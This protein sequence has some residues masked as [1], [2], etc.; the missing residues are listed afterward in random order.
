MVAMLLRKWMKLLFIIVIVVGFALYTF[1][2]LTY[3]RYYPGVS[4]NNEIIVSIGSVKKAEDVVERILDKY[5]GKVDKLWIYKTNI[6]WSRK[7]IQI[8]Y[9]SYPLNY[10]YEF[11]VFILRKILGQIEARTELYFRAPHHPWDNV[12]WI[13][14]DRVH[15]RL[16][17][18][19]N[20]IF[21]GDEPSG[22]GN[23]NALFYLDKNRFV[24]INLV[25]AEYCI[26]NGTS[27]TTFK[28]NGTYIKLPSPCSPRD[29][30]HLRFWYIYFVPPYIHTFTEPY[31]EELA[32]VYIANIV[33][34]THNMTDKVFM[35]KNFR[36]YL[37][38]LRR[39]RDEWIKRFNDTGFTALRDEHG[40]VAELD[41]DSR[42]IP[43]T[44]ENTRFFKEFEENLTDILWHTLIKPILQYIHV[45]ANSL[46]DIMF[47]LLI[48]KHEAIY[49][50][51][52]T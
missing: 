4:G 46:W 27:L 32:P 20:G 43:Q 33:V 23:V 39:L 14:Y 17:I 52:L 1:F 26:P 8:E 44:L 30:E 3:Y 37:G 21:S 24:I 45:H 6:Y 47:A 29:R 48:N 35:D 38:E 12:T 16:L 36:E 7:D 50:E 10:S 9:D 22:A 13:Q 18:Y 2:F 19:H 40:K 31:D 34:I 42:E 15:N 25:P 5:W 41:F 49:L 51:P 11:R 28:Y